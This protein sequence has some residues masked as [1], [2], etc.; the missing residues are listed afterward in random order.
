[1]RQLRDDALAVLSP[2]QRREL[3]DMKDSWKARHRGRFGP[4][5]PE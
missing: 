1:L 5:P 3:E 4:P 2:E